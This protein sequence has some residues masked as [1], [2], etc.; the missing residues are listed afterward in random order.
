MK[1]ALN[2]FG[3]KGKEGKGTV[4]REAWEINCVC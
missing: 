1:K 3:N 4:A 2:M